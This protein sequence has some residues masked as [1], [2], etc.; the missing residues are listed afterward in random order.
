MWQRVPTLSHVTWQGTNAGRMTRFLS[1]LFGWTFRDQGG[2]YFVFAAPSGAWVGVTEVEEV[3]AGNAFV[4]DVEVR[5]LAAY[6]AR[7]K[8]L[9]GTVV[10]ERGEIRAVGV[11]ADARDPDGSLFTMIEFGAG[12]GAA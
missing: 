9:G 1:D 3:R 6:V 7:V 11:Y 4:P 12:S 5:D 10:K 8:Q 2:S